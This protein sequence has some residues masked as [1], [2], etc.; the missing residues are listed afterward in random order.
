MQYSD[1]NSSNFNPQ[2]FITGGGC[3]EGYS[4][5]VCDHEH[6]DWR[7]GCCIYCLG[8]GNA[9]CP[10][11]AV[12][13][14]NTDELKTFGRTHCLYKDRIT[15][16]NDLQKLEE[17]LSSENPDENEI[18][19]LAEKYKFKICKDKLKTLTN[20]VGKYYYCEHCAKSS[21]FHDYI[22]NSEIVEKLKNEYS[23]IY[24]E[25]VQGRE[26]FKD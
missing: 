20:I 4:C 13:A 2:Y 3:N 19:E 5:V 6:S 9:C 12:F 1:I 23:N 11:C 14:H 16:E 25:I 7:S 17:L 18:N 24:H 15:D 22:S 8:C 10:N 26:V 21:N